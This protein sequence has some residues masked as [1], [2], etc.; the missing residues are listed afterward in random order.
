MSR[1]DLEFEKAFWGNCCNTFYEEQKQYVYANLM[2]IDIEGYGFNAHGKTVLD[3]GGGP[4]SMLLKTRNLSRGKVVDPLVYPNWTISRYASNGI[5]VS[6]ERGEDIKESG[7]DEVWIY[8]C[9]QHVD[10]PALIIENALKAGKLIRLFEWI[11]IPAH[12]GHP[13]ELKKAELDKWLGTNG[14][15]INL[16]QAGCYG[17]AYYVACP[18]LSTH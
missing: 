7:W 9:L 5:A 8:N 18:G 6:V 11:N 13:H 2:G 4:V 14:A 3:I 1:N 15:E 17:T 12:E 10:D 16:A